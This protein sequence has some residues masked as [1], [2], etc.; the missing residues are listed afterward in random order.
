MNQKNFQFISD[1]VNA[2]QVSGIRSDEHA[3]NMGFFNLGTIFV[4]VIAPK[5]SLGPLPLSGK[6]PVYA[7]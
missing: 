5:T 3:E 2:R 7:P 4:I 6:N 1:F